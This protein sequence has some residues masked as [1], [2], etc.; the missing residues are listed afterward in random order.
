MKER[1]GTIIVAIAMSLAVS[2]T[3]IPAGET[4]GELADLMGA[5]DTIEIGRAHV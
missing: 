2:T 5:A 1:S 4:K 3:T